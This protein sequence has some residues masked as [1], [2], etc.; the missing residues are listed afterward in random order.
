MSSIS[1]LG[2]IIRIPQ[3]IRFPQMFAI[4]VLKLV[5]SEVKLKSLAILDHLKQKVLISRAYKIFIF[6]SPNALGSPRFWNFEFLAFVSRFPYRLV[7]R[8]CCALFCIKIFVWLTFLLLLLSKY[9]S[10][11]FITVRFLFFDLRLFGSRFGS[12]LFGMFDCWLE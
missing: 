9:C 8:L 11:V 6:D 2:I 4:C 7:V 1:F 10:S 3:W 12:A 5:P